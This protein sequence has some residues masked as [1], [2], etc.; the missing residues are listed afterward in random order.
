M[1][2]L[3]LLSLLAADVEALRAQLAHDDAAQRHAAAEALGA[4]GEA[5]WPARRDLIDRLGDGEAAVRFEAARALVRIGAGADGAKALI[6]RFE[7]VEADLGRLL[8]EAVAGAGGEAVDLLVEC[9][10]PLA[11]LSLGLMGREGVRGLPALLDRASEPMVDEA[12]RRLGPWGAPV[13]PELIDRLR[14]GETAIKARAAW[15]LGLV[16]PAAKEAIPHLKEAEQE[17][18]EAA[19]TAIARIGS[20]SAAREHPRLRKPDECTAKAPER[21]SLL[22]ETSRGEIEVEVVRAWAPHGADRLFNLA[23]V[24]FFRDARFFRVKR[25]F[26]AQ[27]GIHA[28]SRVGGLWKGSEIPDDPPAQKNVRGT[29]AFAMAGPGTRT[30]QL[31]FN[32]RDNPGLD[33][34]GFVPV[35]RVTRGLERLDALNPEYGEEPD[36]QSIQYSGNDYLD[37]HYPRLDAIR[38][39]RILG[40]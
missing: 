13:V 37:R 27:F 24:G 29:L 11:A 36:Q 17:V 22:F 40:K 8:A 4:L 34:Q 19:T 16:G 28:D 15:V 23:T 31:F 2:L 14:F 38:D 39:V 32:L 12:I 3:L 9:P 25:D 6:A 35:G 18:R 33:P 26:V 10:H 21:F 7:T 20:P 30:T 1:T 5:A